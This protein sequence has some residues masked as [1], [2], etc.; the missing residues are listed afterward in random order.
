VTDAATPTPRQ[1]VCCPQC[2]ERLGVRAE[3]AGRKAR[4]G[5]C[6]TVFT[7][8]QAAEKPGTQAATAPPAPTPAQDDDFWNDRRRPVLVTFEC[9][10]CQTRISARV[11]EVGTQVKCPDCGRK[12]VVPPPPKPKTTVAPAAMGGEQ[13]ELAERDEAAPSAPPTLVPVECRLCQTL[14]YTTPDRVGHEIRCPDCGVMTKVRPAPLKKPKAPVLTAD[15]ED[16]LLDPKSKPTKRHVPVPVA[17][18]DAELH[19]HARATTV[20]PDGRLIVQRPNY[21]RPVRPKNPLVTGVWPML[22]T[23]E[24]IARWLMTSIAFGFAGWFL[25]SAL[26]PAVSG[27]AQG[28]MGIFMAIIG[29]LLSVLWLLFAAPTFLTIVAESAE[30]HD[31]IMEP[32][33]WSPF[34]WMGECVQL[35]AAI[36]CASGVGAAIAWG[37]SAGAQAADVALPREAMAAI[38]AVGPL[39]VFPLAMLGTMLEN[40][41]LAVISPRAISTLVK[42]PGPWL[43]FYVETALLVAAATAACFGVV[44]ADESGAIALPVIIMGA[45]VVYTRLLGR[46]AWWISEATAVAVDEE[47]VDESESAHPHLAAARRAAHEKRRRGE[48]E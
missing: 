47:F 2:G 44:V 17:L 36:G 23:Q 7:V 16:Y 12:N 8:G 32:P 21:K 29:A 3:D 39:L 25:Y 15:G 27:V 4:C 43:L 48:T 6:G 18:R 37:L 45:A 38:A 5:K 31:E 28:I 41:A 9:S 1:F 13:Y 30:G 33:S 35:A 40:T 19:S 22:V 42:C 11:G 34:D 14:M 20:G 46:L 26:V 24:V 10:L